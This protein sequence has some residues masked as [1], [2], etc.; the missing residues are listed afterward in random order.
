MEKLLKSKAFWSAVVSV[1]AV[2]VMR[3]TLIPEEIW[4]SIAALLGVV[5][6]IFTIDDLEKGIATTMRET[7]TE[8]RK[9]LGK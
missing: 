1:I 9:E 2:I 4:Q 5:I 3:Y 8:L 6:G 7:I